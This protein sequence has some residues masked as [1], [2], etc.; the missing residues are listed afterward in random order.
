[1]KEIKMRIYGQWTSYT[2]MKNKEISCNCFK[3]GKERVEGER[4]WWC[5]AKY[6]VSLIGIVTMNP[7]HIVNIS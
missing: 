5:L 7:P 4:E 3:W 6:N 2:Y 1:M